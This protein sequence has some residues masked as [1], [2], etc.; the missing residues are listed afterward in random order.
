MSAGTGTHRW[1][2]GL[3]RCLTCER[4]IRTGRTLND[5]PHQMGSSLSAGSINDQS[6]RAMDALKRLDEIRT[7]PPARN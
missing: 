5:Y 7:L 1:E 3:P 4:S 2:S 6:L